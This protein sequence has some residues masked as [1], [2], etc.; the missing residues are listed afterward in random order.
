ML[1][2]PVEALPIMWHQINWKSTEA[3]KKYILCYY[4]SDYKLYE[5]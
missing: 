3:S 2:M 5:T 4:N 1:L